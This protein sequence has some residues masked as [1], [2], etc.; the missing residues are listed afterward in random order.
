MAHILRRITVSLTMV[1]ATIA[2]IHTMAAKPF[3]GRR[4]IT[5]L[6]SGLASDLGSAEVGMGIITDNRGTDSRLICM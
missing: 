3:T 1:R 2:K 4:H 5:G 6:K